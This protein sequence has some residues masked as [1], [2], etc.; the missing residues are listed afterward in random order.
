VEVSVVVVA[1]CDAAQR[2][3]AD[4]N[5]KMAVEAS[6]ASKIA[7]RRQ[8]D[9]KREQGVCTDLTCYARQAL[10]RNKRV[11]SNI[12]LNKWRIRDPAKNRGVM[13]S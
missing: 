4:A 1:V 5:T 3:L 6:T 10:S 7:S 9:A 13:C 11:R 2:S 8:A 12:A